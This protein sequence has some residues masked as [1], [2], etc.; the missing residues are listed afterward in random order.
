MPELDGREPRI[1][2]A[3]LFSQPAPPRH[4]GM[5]VVSAGRAPVSTNALSALRAMGFA[6]DFAMQ[7]D[8]LSIKVGYE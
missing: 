2:G 4:F 6:L 1:K 5:L 3:P 7:F 8:I